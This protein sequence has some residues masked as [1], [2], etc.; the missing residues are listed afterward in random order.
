MPPQMALPNARC[1]AATKS[2]TPA[3]FHQQQLYSVK[4]WALCVVAL[5]WCWV[6]IWAAPLANAANLRDVPAGC[7]E[8]VNNGSFNSVDASWSILAS[9]R[10]ASY[11]TGITHTVGGYAMQLGIVD[12]PNATSISAVEQT[13]NL[14]AGAGSIVLSFWYYT[15]YDASP[16][17]GDLQY[18]DIYNSFN[19]QLIARVI[20]EQSNRRQWVM[21]DFDLTPFASQ[22]IRLVFVVNN[23]GL[24]GRTAMYVDD[25]SILACNSTITPTPTFTS[26]APPT[27]TGTPAPPTGTATFTPSVTWTPL[28]TSTGTAIP[29]APPGCVNALPNSSFESNDSWIFGQDPVPPRF[30]GDVHSGSRAVLMGNPPEYGLA[31]VVTYSSVRQLVSVPANA[32]AIQLRWWRWHRTQEGVDANPGRWSDRQDVITLSPQLE[33]IQILVRTRQND[34]GWQENAVTLDANFYRGKS[35]YIYFNTFNDGNGLRTWTLL[36]DVQFIVCYGGVAPADANIFPTS[37][38]PAVLPTNTAVG[39]SFGIVVTPTILPTPTPLSPTSIAFGAAGVAAAGPTIGPIATV[40]GVVV[41]STPL[42]GAPPTVA[43]TGPQLAPLGT[44][45]TSVRA[46]PTVGANSG[47]RSIFTSSGTGAFA[48]MIVILALII[49]IVWA[50]IRMLRG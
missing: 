44:S 21:E 48:V 20:S 26:T 28:P 38:A 33:P 1:T 12:L 30:V 27:D 3:A 11:V 14:P 4:K 24:N 2:S 16:G 37:Y 31:N 22:Q 49:L 35:F 50:I 15:S 6:A 47:L 46:A 40:L 25:V 34:G 8:L 5:L 13:I 18:V 29:T 17:A 42:Q 9:A 36:D 23:D 10:P 19:N 43:I 45:Q 32:T 39:A 41:T 7:A